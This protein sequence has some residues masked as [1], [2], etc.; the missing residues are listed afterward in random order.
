MITTTIK[1]DQRKIELTSVYIPHSGYADVLTEKMYK[2]IETHCDKK[3]THPNLQ[4]SAWAW[5]T[6]KGTIQQKRDLDEAVV[7]DTEPCST[8][9]NVQK[10]TE[11]QYTFRSPSGKE[12]QLDRRNR[13]YCT[14]A[15]VNDMIHLG[16]DHRSA[17]AHFRFPCAKKEEDWKTEN[18]NRIPT[19]IQDHDTFHQWSHG[20]IPTHQKISRKSSE[21]MMNLKKRLTG[22]HEVAAPEESQILERKH[23]D[24]DGSN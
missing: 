18:R 14:D 15:E 8:Q 12:K 16:S 7:D 3:K 6:H 2:N 5:G 11:K 22:K 9:H 13:R 19:E 20:K 17:T 21:D 10:T 24:D 1:C 23:N 4:R